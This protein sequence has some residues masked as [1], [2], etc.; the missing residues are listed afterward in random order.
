MKAVIV[1]SIQLHAKPS[2]EDFI[3][4]T[5]QCRNCGTTH[6]SEF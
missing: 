6:F 3:Q 2:G 4:K 5:L 1:L